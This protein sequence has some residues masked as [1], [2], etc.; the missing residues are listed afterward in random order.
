MLEL[1]GKA[2]IKEAFGRKLDDAGFALIPQREEGKEQMRWPFSAARLRKGMFFA[3][4][5]SG[6]GGV[7]CLGVV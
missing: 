2:D 5:F 3:Y 4:Y 1:V 7:G 6:F